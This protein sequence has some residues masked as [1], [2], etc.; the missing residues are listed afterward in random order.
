[1]PAIDEI[2]RQNVPPGLK[3]AEFVMLMAAMMAIPALSID[4]MLPALPDIGRDL[5]VADPN[6]RQAIIIFFFLGLSAGSL[7]YGPL[8]DRFGRRLIL[9]GAM[10]MLLVAT[11]I[12]AIAPSFQIM[13]GAR[14]VAGF[15]GASCRVMVVGIVRDCFKGDKMARI[16]S[17]IMSIFIIV[18]M[19]A[20]GFGQFILWFAPWRWIFWIL[21]IL[22]C[23]ISVWAAVRLPETLR[24]ENRMSI[25]PRDLMTTFAR[26][27]TTRNS[28]GHMVASGFMFSG[29]I[30]FL[31]SVQQIFFDMFH[32]P[33]L[34]PLAFAGIAVWMGIGSLCNGRLVEHFGARRLSQSAVIALILLSAL[35][36]LI[37]VSGH[38]NVVVFIVIQSM[39]SACFSF[40]GA[41]F[42]AISLEPFTKGAGLASSIQASLTTLM[43]AVLGGFVGAHFDGTALPM[44]LG[45]M[46]FGVMSFL[47]IAWAE[48]WRLFRRPGLGHLR[49]EG[50]HPPS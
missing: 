18:P 19:M 25:G 2:H 23:V 6:D 42:S 26:I 1:M 12:C 38:E 15:C 47:V 33:D 45:F 24:P 20:P 28:I 37:I 27:V 35:H 40:A 10:A 22:I 43:S 36:C 30:G 5:R 31:V 4:P 14:L 39:T 49:T 11:V 16:M 29:L 8:S 7:F 46:A 9:I 48:R 34:F 41:N 32:M 50:M 44:S 21:A 17:F 13:L 3:M